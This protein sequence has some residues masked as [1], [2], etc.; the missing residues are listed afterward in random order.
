[1][2]FATVVGHEQPIESLRRAVAEDRIATA[3]LLV[4]PPN[5]GKTLMATEFAKAVNCE[6][7]E[8]GAEAEDIDACDECHN[9]VRI[10]QENHPDL[11]MLRPAVSIDVKEPPP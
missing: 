11:L 9:C 7:R 8:P 4:G 10:D 6:A 1:M 3:Y 5:I 2:S